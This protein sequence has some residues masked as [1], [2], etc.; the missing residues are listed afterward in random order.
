[1]KKLLLSFMILL[2]VSEI[3]A[4]TRYWVGAASNWAVAGN[5]NTVSG[6]GGASGLP[7][8]GDNVVFD[9]GGGDCII[10]ATVALGA[11]TITM[12]GA[13]SGNITF[14]S[15]KNVT[16]AGLTCSG[17]IYKATS[18]GTQSLGDVLINGGT[19]QVSTSTGFVATSL[20]VTSGTFNGG[21]KP[22][23]INGTVSL[24]GG[25]IVA[26]SANT[27][28]ISNGDFSFTGGSFTHNS[29]TVKFQM[30]NALQ[31]VNI[32]P[33]LTFYNLTIYNNTQVN[34]LDVN[35]AGA[36]I[37]NGTFT[38]A[39][40]G[41]YDINLLG[42]TLTL[43]GNITLTG[44]QGNNSNAAFSSTTL[45]TISGSGAQLFTGNSSIGFGK[46]PSIT[47]N[48][49]G[50]S[51]SLSGYVNIYGNLTYTAGSVSTTGSTVTMYGTS[52]LNSNGMSFNILNIGE[53]AIDVGS[54]T[55]FSALT[56]SGTITVNSSSSLSTNNFA[57][58]CGGS[59]ANGGTFTCGSSTITLTG[60]SAQSI[61]FGAGHTLSTLVVNKSGNTATIN[62]SLSISNLLTSIAG[63]LNANGNIT[64]ISNA[65]GTANIGPVSGI[66]SGN[67]I[68]QRYIP[69]SGRR[70]RFLAAPI[71]G[72][73]IRNGWQQNMFITG[74]TGGA[75]P[76]GSAN[77]N[78]N[79]FDWTSSNASSIYTYSES[80]GTWSSPANTT[81][82]NLSPGVG[83]RVFVRGDRSNT[84]VLDGSVSTQSAAV[85]LNLTGAIQ[86]GD[87]SA[88]VTYGGTGAGWNLVGN[89]YACAYDFN[90]QYGAGVGFSNISNT[91]Y[92]WDAVS[93][94]YISYNASSHSGTLTNGL[95]PSGAAFFLLSSGA[96]PSF[97]FKEAYKS[98]S[99][100]YQMFK[101]S[102]EELT[103]KMFLDSSNY[104]QYI[105]K[106]LSGATKNFDNF[107]IKKLDNP[108]MNL[109]SYGSDNTKLSLSA[110]PI[111]TG[112]DTVR[113]DA[114]APNGTYTF[115]FNGITNFATNL[116]LFLIDNYT[117]TVTNLRSVSQYA[118][119]INNSVP[120]S[121]G[122]NRF[123]IIIGNN[124]GSL[125]IVLANFNAEKTADKKVN[126]SWITSSEINNNHFE[127][128]RSIDQVNFI[129]IGNV[130]GHGNSVLS[131]NYQML[132]A[133][134]NINAI[135]YY[136]LKQVDGDNKFTYSPTVPV[137]FNVDMAVLNHNSSLVNVY[138]V[139]AID[140]ISIS[141]NNTYKGDVTINVYNLVGKLILS[142]TGTISK[143]NSEVS[144][145]ISSLNAGVYMIEVSAKNGE[146]VEKS[147]FVK[148]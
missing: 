37:V 85:T 34:D 74:G 132:D 135:N 71:S 126:V 84:G 32:D 19:F 60:G 61:D 21:S 65:S 90:A 79:G 36:T 48:K 89:P 146:F 148:E 83:Y 46:L 110:F 47:I 14:A 1:M 95:I 77:Y 143:S 103:I 144:Q 2:T 129:K 70:W 97:T 3:N 6:G 23:I 113:L 93:N 17:G 142:T 131:N 15:A 28:T 68:V 125:P 87:V 94:A 76:V 99:T 116:D 98:T 64:L 96:S 130:K 67:F 7:V 55:L 127:V 49:S 140:N 29:G 86:T 62:N 114:E 42:G 40:N 122:G 134:P 63:T 30:N 128:E 141:L 11:G 51:L 16:A 91:I 69:T 39:T 120:A 147:K 22:C 78:T 121:F 109:S 73:S 58:S 139:P 112:Y 107:D 136:R 20:T 52:N 50:G 12:T 137:D 145:N 9:G 27:M 138:P 8:S 88:T 33:S 118:F 18:G 92:V 31:A 53:S 5:W 45:I 57:V 75:G 25:S 108:T 133:N 38:L 82:T 59:F 115:Y 117:S 105:F 24:S 80:S 101:T 66:L 56:S 10:G 54:I 111:N 102:D 72:V 41:A 124:G 104:D 13:Y 106:Y 44:Y 35:F 4:T 26:P 100:P 123:M 81:S 43:G 119:T